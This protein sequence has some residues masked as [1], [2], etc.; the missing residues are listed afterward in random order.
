MQ[1]RYIPRITG[2]K[3]RTAENMDMFLPDESKWQALWSGWRELRTIRTGPAYV[4]EMREE[5][6]TT[7]PTERK[8]M[9][10]LQSQVGKYPDMFMP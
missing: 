6:V 10:K 3:R 9:S 2:Q 8:T 4:R 5:S 7:L 1:P